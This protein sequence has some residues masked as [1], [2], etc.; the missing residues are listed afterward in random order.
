MTEQMFYEYGFYF[1]LGWAICQFIPESYK[2][3]LKGKEDK[4]E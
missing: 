3:K 1:L 2:T 4:H